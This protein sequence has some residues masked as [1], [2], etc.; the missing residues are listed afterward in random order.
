MAAPV[1]GD[2]A[3]EEAVNGARTAQA[4]LSG[5]TPSFLSVLGPTGMTISSSVH[6]DCYST[7]TAS[8]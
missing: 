2:R 5:F 7:F 3:R 6:T 1:H 8:L 4:C